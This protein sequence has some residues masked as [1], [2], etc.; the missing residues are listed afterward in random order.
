[1][2]KQRATGTD[3]RSSVAGKIASSKNL[4][5]SASKSGRKAA[6]SLRRAATQLR[7]ARSSE[8]T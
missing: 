6:D 7:Q 4:G 3:G 1:M 2:A 8:S 5:R